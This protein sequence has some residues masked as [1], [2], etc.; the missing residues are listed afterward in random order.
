M[1]CDRRTGRGVIQLGAGEFGGGEFW[2][3]EVGRV[4]FHDR[5]GRTDRLSLDIRGVGGKAFPFPLLFL[6]ALLGFG[7][8]VTEVLFGA[9]V[10]EFAVPQVVLLEDPLGAVLRASAGGLVEGHRGLA[11]LGVVRLDVVVALLDALALRAGAGLLLQFGRALGEVGD[12]AV[13]EGFGVAELVDAVGEFG[14]AGAGEASELVE[15]VLRVGALLRGAARAFT[16][17][18]PLGFELVDVVHDVGEV[19]E[20]CALIVEALGVVA[21]SS[22]GREP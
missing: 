22:L 9:Q 7:E 15:F 21:L 17:F 8:S 6:K 3:G 2:R 19:A 20:S 5:D 18:A 11:V 16:G 13:G 10:V 12:L 14:A 1:V 4:G